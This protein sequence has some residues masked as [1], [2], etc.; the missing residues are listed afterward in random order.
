MAGARNDLFYYR[1]HDI[2]D[3]TSEVRGATGSL[4]ILSPTSLGFSAPEGMEF[5]EWNTERDGSGTAYAVG[6]TVS[7]TLTLYA[8]WVASEPTY[9]D[10]NG[11]KVYD[12]KIKQYINAQSSSQRVIGRV[13]TTDYEPDT[14]RITAG[15]GISFGTSGDDRERNLAISIDNSI[16]GDTIQNSGSY[17]IGTAGIDTY[18]NGPHITCPAGTYFFVGAWTFQSGSSSGQRNLQ[19]AFRSGTSGDLWGERVRIMAAAN[20]YAILNVSAIRTLSSSTTVYLAGSSSMTTGSTGSCY[21]T[22]VRIK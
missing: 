2:S 14:L 8:I 10:L 12:E 20:N 5:S 11:L 1:N 4:N 15:T 21:I 13:G 17:K 9:L 16:I 7:A 19:V 18:T 22:A 3:N 6:A